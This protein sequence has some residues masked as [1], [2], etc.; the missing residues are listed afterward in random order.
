MTN[1]TA[2]DL[3]T[4]GRTRRHDIRA[5]RR[6]IALVQREDAR[7]RQT[8]DAPQR[9]TGSL[10]IT[11]DRLM[12]VRMCA[13]PYNVLAGSGSPAG[14]LG[15]SGPSTTTEKSVMQKCSKVACGKS[16]SRWQARSGGWVCSEHAKE[17]PS[18]VKAPSVSEVGAWFTGQPD[19]QGCP[20]HDGVS[21]GP[22][23]VCVCA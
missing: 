11:H 17:S 22:Q 16:A 10:P 20:R 15:L 21:Y 12:R 5:F 8:R 1:V 9:H 23:G 18:S 13:M 2:L 14:S 3:T 19:R 6:R 7:T 4:R